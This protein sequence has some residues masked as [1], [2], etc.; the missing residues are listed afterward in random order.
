MNHG[1]LKYTGVIADADAA[2]ADACDWR[3]VAPKFAGVM[4]SALEVFERIFL[5]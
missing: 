4:E 2:M 1:F 5:R 3:Y